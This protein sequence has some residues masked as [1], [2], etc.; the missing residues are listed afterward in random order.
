MFK[1]LM[2]LQHHT[3]RNGCC[4]EVGTC[5]HANSSMMY[6]QIYVMDLACPLENRRFTTTRAFCRETICGTRAG[7]N[8]VGN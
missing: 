1:V 8:R 6:T 3:S 4:G 7:A 2:P 5:D